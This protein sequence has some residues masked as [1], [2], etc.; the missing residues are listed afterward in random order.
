MWAIHCI[1]WKG[2]TASWKSPDIPML[3]STSSSDRPS[4]EQI[5]LRQSC[6]LCKG[7]L[8]LQAVVLSKSSTSNSWNWFE[9]KNAL[10]YLQVSER[11]SLPKIWVMRGE[12]RRDYNCLSTQVYTSRRYTLMIKVVLKTSQ[13]ENVH[14]EVFRGAGVVRISD[15][16]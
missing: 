2:L 11:L 8:F 12:G 14:L 3:S 9:Y 5:S 7:N 10:R 16:H 4:L 1:A 15:R 13:G 6:R